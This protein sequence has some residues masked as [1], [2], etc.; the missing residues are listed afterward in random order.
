MRMK[1]LLATA[2][3]MAALPFAAQAQ[4]SCQDDERLYAMADFSEAQ[5][6]GTAEPLMLTA[7]T[8]LHLTPKAR[9]VIG[10]NMRLLDGD[11]NAMQMLEG[12]P[13][14]KIEM[15]FPVLYNAFE[16]AVLRGDN[17]T[18]GIL[19][20]SF[21]AQPMDSASFLGLFTLVSKDPA[22]V[23]NLSSGAGISP[24]TSIGSR[25]EEPVSYLHFA[26]FF[27]RFGGQV[28]GNNGKAWFTS[29]SKTEVTSVEDNL[30]HSFPRLSDQCYVAKESILTVAESAGSIVIDMGN[31][32]LLDHWGHSSTKGKFIEVY[33][34]WV[35][36]GAPDDA[37]PQSLFD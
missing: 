6:N 14:V 12:E 15:P 5:R 20:R 2:I 24:H 18:S 10:N 27:V 3:T 8:Y 13:P 4:A 7:D 21:R 22:L 26:D 17:R 31:H 28:E 11:C 35:E 1:K 29:G 16:D 19:V 32:N 36:S 30:T 34:D 33:N 37:Q 25:C 23:Q 9:E